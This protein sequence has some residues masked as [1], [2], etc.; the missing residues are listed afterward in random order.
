MTDAKTVKLTCP[1]EAARSRNRPVALRAIINRLKE[2]RPL[3]TNRFV[4]AKVTQHDGRVV[5]TINE[6]LSIN[7][8]EVSFVDYGHRGDHYDPNARGV[9]FSI[10]DPA[11]RDRQRRLL[12]GYYDAPPRLYEAER[13][14][15]SSIS[16]GPTRQ[17]LRA[18]KTLR[19]PN[20]Y[21]PDVYVVHWKRGDWEAR[22]F[23]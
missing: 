18:G 16:G 7:G 22:L 11:L 8:L 1:A 19:K 9:Y 6:S 14:E 4:A 10:H 20:E 15:V 3:A 21:L 2:L 23:G 17:V 5:E 12:T 13:A